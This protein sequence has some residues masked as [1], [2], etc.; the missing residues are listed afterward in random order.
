MAADTWIKREYGI[1]PAIASSYCL[2]NA[3]AKK[4]AAPIVFVHYTHEHPIAS[5]VM[6]PRSSD[7]CTLFFFLTGKFGFLVDD[8]IYDPSYGNV[9]IF[10]NH[11]KFTSVFYTNSHVD[12]YQIE[13]PAAFFE[14]VSVPELFFSASQESK[15]N[16][17]IPDRLSSEQVL[18]KLKQTENLILSNNEQ[19][20]LL[21]YANIL[22]ILG[23]L[24]SQSAQKEPAAARVPAKLKMAV[25]Y[26]HN[27]YPTLS[28]IEEVAAFC[29]ITNT[30]LSRMFRK[31][32]QC[33]P[34]EYLNRL[35]ISEAKYLLSTGSSLTDACYCSG[36]NN[37]T[38]FIS[39]FKSHTGITPAKFKE[40]KSDM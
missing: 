23:I 6:Y 10:R 20:Q 32:F 13:F 40:S 3:Y 28:S 2:L 34:N 26:I 17:L 39:K 22:Q 7:M 21:A 31:T 29:N 4:A 9:M 38:Y 35:R 19:L 1:N 30:Y 18:D 36:F 33:T 11:E 12:Y 8:V 16:M 5:K 27:N 14:A 24:A 25:E 15:Q 37:Y